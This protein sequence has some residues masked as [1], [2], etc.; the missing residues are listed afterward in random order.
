MTTRVQVATA[1]LL[2][3]PTYEVD[4]G[5]LTR[6]RSRLESGV[7]GAAAALPPTATL[8][9]GVPLLRRARYRPDQLATADEPFAWKPAFVRRSLGLEVVRACA[10]GRFRGPAAAVGPVADEAVAAWERTGWRTFHWEPWFAGLGS[11]ARSVVL[12]AAVTWATPLWAT[13]DWATLRGRADL[14]GPDDRWS[15]PGP[16]AVNLKG[17]VEARIRPS[18]GRPTLVSM[19]SGQPGDGWRDELAFLA[20]AG[21]LGAPECPVAG[22]VVGLWPESGLRLAVEVGENALISAVDRVID[23]VTVTAA[24]RT[25]GAVA[26]R[27]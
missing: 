26:V 17:R 13:F 15:S 21:V 3:P 19:A 6:V 25:T 2:A 12:A 7:A 14:G 8:D 18:G 10:E 5:A 23:A 9:V 27:A 24:A 20:L 11:G 4:E 1:G 16:R 22:R